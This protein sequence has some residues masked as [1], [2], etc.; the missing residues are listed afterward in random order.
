MTEQDNG[1]KIFRIKLIVR[2][3]FVLCIMAAMI[4][5]VQARGTL[6]IVDEVNR[7]PAPA[8]RLPVEGQMLK[9]RERQD[10]LAQEEHKLI[11]RIN[12][13]E[14]KISKAGAEAALPSDS[15][16][17][18]IPEK[19]REKLTALVAAKKKQFAEDAK[20]AEEEKK[21]REAELARQKKLEEERERVRRAKELT[22][23]AT[24][25]I[26]APVKNA[27]I[28]IYLNKKFM[29][30]CVGKNYIRQYYHIAVPKNIANPKSAKDD[31]LPPVGTYY[32]CAREVGAKGRY[33]Q[34][35][36]PGVEDA[37]KALASGKIDT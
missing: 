27:Y 34:I 8:D 33:M 23:Y 30:I 32:V 28:L 15:E 17:A 16:L 35:S 3:F 14:E 25:E 29:G 19:Y 20:K 26:T 9:E 7:Q 31:G 4:F 6:L 12:T 22:A 5:L 37:K 2:A 11:E 13:I 1:E 10:M 36:Y 21:K 18:G 24:G